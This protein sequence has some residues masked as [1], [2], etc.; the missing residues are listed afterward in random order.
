MFSITPFG[1]KRAY[2]ECVLCCPRNAQ[3]H[4]QDTGV[5]QHYYAPI[6]TGFHRAPL[7]FTTEESAYIIGCNAQFLGNHSRTT[8]WKTVFYF[9]QFVECC[10]YHT[11][12]YLWVNTIYCLQRYEIIFNPPNSSAFFIHCFS[13]QVYVISM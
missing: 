7:T 6:R 5:V 4:L 10:A 9:S 2:L 13:G 11:I 8:T 12:L 3:C 1:A